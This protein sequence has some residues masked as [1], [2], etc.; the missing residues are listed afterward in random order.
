MHEIS[1]FFKNRKNLINFVI[2]LLL[3]II[4]PLAIN[5]AQKTQ[6]FKSRATEDPIIFSGPNFQTRNGQPVVKPTP[7]SSG[8]PIWSVDIQITAPVP[9]AD[10]TPWEKRFLEP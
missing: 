2:L 8:N 3:A 6:I 4:L 5:L 1:T 7:D 10:T 9:P